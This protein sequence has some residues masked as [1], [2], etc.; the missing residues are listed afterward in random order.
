MASVLLSTPLVLL[1]LPSPAIVNAQKQTNVTPGMSISTTSGSMSWSSPSGRFAFGFYPKG[2]G[3]AIGV[4]LATTPNM[5]VVWTANRND[6]PI[7]NGSIRFSVGG[8]LLWSAPGGR[9]EVIAQ[10]S[11]P[12]T[13]GSMLDTGNFVLY[14]SSHGIVWST[15]SIPTDTLLPGQSLPSQNQLYSSVSEADQ[16]QGNYRLNN[17]ED[18][19][20]VLYAV[21]TSDIADD[22]YWASNTF[23]IGFPLTLSLNS[24]GVL[25]LVGNNSRFTKNLTQAKAS[26]SQGGGEIYYRATLDPDGI[27]RLYS[28]T[29]WKNGSS[30]KAVEWAALDDR[31]LVKGVCGLNSYCSLKEDEEPECLCPPGFD[32]VDPNQIQRGCTR[33]STSGDCSNDHSNGK[34]AGLEMHDM[35][36]TAWLNKPFYIFPSTTSLDDCEAACLSDCF[37]EAALFKDNVCTKQMLPLKYGRTDGN[38][39]LLIKVGAMNPGE[40]A[41]T[42]EK[43][44]DAHAKVIAVSIALAAFSIIVLAI[45]GF[46]FWRYWRFG[47]YKTLK[48]DNSVLDEETTLRSYSYKELEMA[49]EDFREEL[50]KGAFGTVFRGAFSKGGRMIAVKRLEKMVEDGEREFQREVKAIG[51]A[52]HRNLVKLFGFCN[53]G[54]NRLLVYEFMS[55]GSL[56]KLLFKTKTYPSWEERVGIAMDVAKGLQY[57]HEELEAHI[58]HCDIKPEN[59][60]IDDFG[61]AKIADFGLAKLLMPDQT[62]TFTGVR[63][64]RGYLA[65]E[66]YKNAPITVKADVYSYGIVL[67]EIICCRRNME[68]EE[69]GNVRILSEWVYERF[70]AGELEWLKKDQEVDDTELERI[71]K[72]GLWCVQNDL[73]LRPSMKTV[74]LM[75]EDHIQ[76]PLPPAPASFML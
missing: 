65:P 57:L 2:Q 36:N 55:N 13:M 29:F 59:I 66:W 11:E 67:F 48:H 44:N 76:V 58:I 31:C 70:L 18:A 22:A 46:L 7:S 12:A 10:L 23:L 9:E 69:D 25:Y 26:S 63:G 41:V 17:Q 62:R 45:S 49:T 28:H 42:C 3:F 5:T 60:L 37:C 47:R 56:A 27:L 39:T 52:H 6:P 33:N 72:V 40:G 38:D 4:W 54:S 35:K 21:G 51:R 75:L 15:F 53:E 32:Y 61:T 64:T 20:L 34:D 16:S 74:I 19:N 1:F 71:V 30:T 50:G 43:K 24:K 68:L 8:S 73:N 14:N